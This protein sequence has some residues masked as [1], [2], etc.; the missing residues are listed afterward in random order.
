MATTR[1]GVERNLRPPFWR[2]LHDEELVIRLLM[3]CE[4]AAGIKLFAVLQMRLVE[5]VD[6]TGTVASYVIQMQIALTGSPGVEA[7]KVC[8]RS[9]LM[10]ASNSLMR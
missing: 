8:F 3:G 6:R 4:Q 9:V 7:K 5:T 1:L 10:A 2:S